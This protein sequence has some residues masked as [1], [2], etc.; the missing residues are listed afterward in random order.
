[1]ES[2]REKIIQAVERV[3]MLRRELA[4]AEKNLDA[5]LPA[6][7]SEKSSPPHTTGEADGQFVF[8]P[9]SLPDKIYTRMTIAPTKSE[10]RAEDFSDLGEMPNI[11][12]ALFRMFK[13]GKLEKP[14]HGL[15]A[16]AHL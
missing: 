12:S 9:G 11:R 10:F 1:M 6:E 4:E 5:L 15:Y 13:T 14:G 16:V 7:S 3:S 8:V 2:N